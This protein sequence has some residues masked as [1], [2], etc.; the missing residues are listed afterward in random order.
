MFLEYVYFIS[1][2]LWGFLF[3]LYDVTP[4]HLLFSTSITLRATEWHN[5][6][7]VHKFYVHKKSFY[8]KD[9]FGGVHLKHNTSGP[10]N[11]TKLSYLDMNNI[12]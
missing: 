3:F 4:F 7:Y 9:S 12:Q 6:S 5:K 10:E 1:V 2:I 11:S 8:H